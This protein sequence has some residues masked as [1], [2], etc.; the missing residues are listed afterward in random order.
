MGTRAYS[1][2]SGGPLAERADAL[3]RALGYSGRATFYDDL[4]HYDRSE[5]L[6]IVT[7]AF[8]VIGVRAVFGLTEGASRE[9]FKPVVYIGTATDGAEANR[10][11]QRVWTQGAVPIP[12]IVLAE[13]VQLRHAFAPPN[14][15]L[16]TLRFDPADA[17]IEPQLAS[18]SAEALS[19]SIF[20]NDFRIPRADAIDNRL[21]TAIENLNRYACLIYSNLRGKPV[22]VNA[23]IGRFLYLYVLVDRHLVDVSWMKSVIKQAGCGSDAFAEAVLFKQARVDAP[24]WTADEAWAVF[25]GVDQ[26]INGSVFHIPV[27]DRQLL[28]DA[29]LELVH[30]VVRCDNTVDIDGHQISFLDVSFDVL[31]TE[32][33]SAIYQR[34]LQLEDG[35]AQRAEG[36]FYTPP[37]VA[38]YVIARVNDEITLDARSRV[39]DPAAGSGAFLVA[40]YRRILERNTPVGGWKPE[41]AAFARELLKRCIFGIEK[42]Q[43]AANV[44][45]F[46][47]YLTMLDYVG[48]TDIE[49]LALAAGSEKLLPPMQDNIVVCDAFDT[50]RHPG[51]RFT[52]VVGNPPWVRT[53]RPGARRNQFKTEDEAAITQGRTAREVSSGPSRLADEA[54]DPARPVMHG[55]LSDKFVWMAERYLVAPDGVL[56]LI[57]PT[58][59]LVGRQSERFASALASLTTLRLVANLS[60]L[61]Y[62]LFVEARASATVVVSRKRIPDPLSTVSVYRPRLS[63][64]PVGRT[65]DVWSL[66]VSQTDLQTVRLR[67][68]QAGDNGWLGPLM[69]G[70]FDRRM[71]FALRTWADARDMTVAAFLRRSRLR[72]HRGGNP[73]E[74]GVPRRVL[75]DKKTAENL[76]SITPAELRK[77]SS[78][79]L[80]LFS[81]NVLI[82]PRNFRNLR[83]LDSPYAFTSTYYG[84]APAARWMRHEKIYEAEQVTVSQPKTNDDR[85]KL[86][87]LCSFLSSG[88]VEYFASLF[89]AT[90]LM[91]GARLEKGDIGVLP[92][93]FE[94]ADDPAFR[95][96]HDSTTVDDAI[97]DA[98]GAGDDLR[99]AVKEFGSFNRH[100]IDGKLPFDM[101]EVVGATTIDAFV[102][103]LRRELAGTFTERFAPSIKVGHQRSRSIALHVGFGRPPD[104]DILVDMP[105]D[106][107]FVAASV[108]SFD[109]QSSTGQVVKSESRFAWTSEQAVADAEV[110]PR[111]VMAQTV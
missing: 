45:R 34:F 49:E 50:T 101:F 74:T 10:L 42:N 16:S 28:P 60:H 11:H 41:H 24:T 4:T 110:L 82:V 38:D 72:M 9:A 95:A 76:F 97:L 26:V 31:R 107:T 17:T 43:Q 15:D 103:R 46:S 37:F 70:S 105:L 109:R 68:F 58:T 54:T 80:P 106:S 48:G 93:P 32:T 83:L 57:L 67:E 13:G 5:N 27:K 44:C 85:S 47:L 86:L 40:A 7:T 79:Y 29:V 19:A 61:R 33:I 75:P 25:D 14:G 94:S 78:K 62:R 1:E 73:E 108:L 71:R 53:G 100:Y 64:L 111:L 65:G 55:R 66:M 51:G 84:I 22:L 77:V 21:V 92:C 18:V 98:M 52:H 12:L 3:C 56:G 89:G 59:S 99:Q 35:S 39:I 30:R 90:Y 2:H 102:S 20:W 88:V 8:D 104:A 69:L 63:S 81:G 36:A 96:L 6:H 87:A 23:L 91:D